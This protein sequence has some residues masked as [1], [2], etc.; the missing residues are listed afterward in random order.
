MDLNIISSYNDDFGV[1]ERNNYV[2]IYYNTRV[3]VEIVDTSYIQ[4]GLIGFVRFQ[5]TSLSYIHHMFVSYDKNY[6]K[7]SWIRA[8]LGR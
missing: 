3:Y 8:K 6:W 5:L 4:K 1:Q 2:L 7:P